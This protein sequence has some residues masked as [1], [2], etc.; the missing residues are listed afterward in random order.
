V[1]ALIARI[2]DL[3]TEAQVVRCPYDGTVF[4]K[5]GACT[6]IDTCTGRL[7]D[8]SKHGRICYYCGKRWCD[9]DPPN[10]KSHRDD[11]QTNPK[12]CIWFLERDH[13]L[14]RSDDGL[15]ALQDFHKWRLTRL[16]HE[17]VYTQVR[18]TQKLL[19]WRLPRWLALASVSKARAL[20][21]NGVS[22]SGRGAPLGGCVRQAP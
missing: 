19:A 7:A 21:S 13:P 2:T 5:D 20:T 14:L 1:D 15:A 22:G 3:I 18:E 6:H 17:H 11:W 4:E 12:R 16:L 9:V 8:G 10:S